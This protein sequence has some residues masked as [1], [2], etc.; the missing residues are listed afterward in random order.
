ML[1]TLREL[2]KRGIIFEDD[3]SSSTTEHRHLMYEG[4][5]AMIP[6]NS[7]MLSMY[8][9]EQP[10]CEIDMFG[11]PTDVPG[12]HYM[13]IITGGTISLSARSMEDQTKRQTLLDIMD[14]ISTVEGQEMLALT[15]SGLSCLSECKSELLTECDA[16]RNCVDSGRI[17]FA[18]D[19][20]SNENVKVILTDWL[21]GSAD[22]EA[23][24]AAL[25]AMPQK[26]STG[27]LELEPIGKASED[28]TVLET[29][30]YEADVMR[31]ITGADV[32]LMLNNNYYKANLAQIFEGD[33]VLPERFYLKGVADADHLTTYEITGANLK[34]LMEHPIIN[35]QEINC[36]YACSGLK[37]EYAPP[38]D[39]NENVLSLTLANGAGIDDD[40]V[41]TVAAWATCIDE[42]YISRVVRTFEDAGR[43]EDMMTSAIAKAG[44]IAPA[45]DGRITLNWD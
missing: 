43:N 12:E 17:F 39:M 13:K 2:F 8:G 11:Y 31:D 7:S 42:R 35:G 5:V 23:T 32:A 3:F 10:D 36:M 19:F 20:G 34:A 30:I 40:A 38:R 18:E 14:Y 29:S 1:E 15:F 21:L 45:N 28:F 44:T 22:M 33:I 26:S 41:Y 6:Y 37:M 24:L 27:K 9:E 4:K 16:I 25:D